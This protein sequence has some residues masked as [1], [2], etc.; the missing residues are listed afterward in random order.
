MVC[1]SLGNLLPL[2]NN[3]LFHYC[4]SLRI[5]VDF[6]LEGVLPNSGE[7]FLY[8]SQRSYIGLGLT[9]ESF[10]D[11]GFTW[12]SVDDLDSQRSFMMIYGPMRDVLMLSIH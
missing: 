7:I 5:G 1:C 2:G 4:D 9:G 11:T 3:Y 8:N 6:T 12:E 10:Y